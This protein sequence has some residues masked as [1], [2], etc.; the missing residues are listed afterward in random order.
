MHQVDAMDISHA[1][2]NACGF[3]IHLECLKYVSVL[4]KRY[5][6]QSAGTTLNEAKV[7]SLNPPLPSYVD[8]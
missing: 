2:L 5:I 7:T 6:A 3:E 8:I 1:R 4:S